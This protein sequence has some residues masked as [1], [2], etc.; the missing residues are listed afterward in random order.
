[1]RPLQCNNDGDDCDDEGEAA[2]AAGVARCWWWQRQ[3]KLQAMVKS[4]DAEG[5][6]LFHSHREFLVQHLRWCVRRE[7]QSV[8][9]GV[10]SENNNHTIITIY[11]AEPFYPPPPPPPP[12]SQ[13][14]QQIQAGV[15]LN[16]K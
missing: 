3:E 5:W 6:G 8:E 2:P 13:Q 1:M 4:F 9:A 12:R 15:S 16:D 14:Q 11:T 10:G 7:V